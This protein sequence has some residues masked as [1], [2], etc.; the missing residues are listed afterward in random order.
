MKHQISDEELIYLYLNTRQNY[1]FETLYKRYVRKVYCRCFS[2]TKD[3]A[4][5]EDFTHDIFLRVF[6]KLES[7]QK[8]ATFS[9]WLYSIS[10]NY[11]MDQLRT[12]HKSPA[13]LSVDDDLVS[14]VA[15]TEKAE[16]LDDP[17]D[18]LLR[19]LATITPEEQLFLRMKYE[20]GLDINEIARLFDLKASTVK[21]RL[22]RIRDKVRLR[23]N[24]QLYA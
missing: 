15:E 8:R 4:K 14:N 24:N 7:F 22:K 23:C 17:F 3:T 12:A 20:D 1:Y 2:L 21:M 9:S 11:C 18:H 16:L 19:I 6:T 10:H 5:A 13:L